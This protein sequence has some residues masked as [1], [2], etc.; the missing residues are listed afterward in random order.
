MWRHLSFP[1]LLVAAVGFSG[2]SFDNTPKRL[3]A[4]LPPPVTQ[5]QPAS[6]AN[7]IPSQQVQA[8]LVVLNDTGFEKSAPA[9]RKGTLEHLGDQLKAELEK[10]LPLQLSS[11]VYPEGLSP[12]GSSDRFIQMAKEQ[13]VPY[14]LVALLS[15]SEWEVFD[16]LPLQ[17]MQ[18]GGGMRSSGL[19]GYRAENYAR[20]ELALID[21]QTGQPLVT[22]DGQAW[23]A[24]ERLA[25]PLESNVY[26]VVRRDLTQP[27][28]YPDSEENAHETLRWV[29]G[30]GAIDQ[31]VMHLE[32]L[33]KKNRT[34]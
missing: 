4:Y 29:S 8:M 27:P 20:L 13:Q 25:V 15:S 12:Q 5:A 32:E 31:A 16:R 17:G 22:T 3:M 14:V 18:Q 26:P 34:A 7:N 10:Q 6:N 24:L 23:A 28:I 2:C 19:P 11:V 33:W 21:A 9:L 1:F 30:Q